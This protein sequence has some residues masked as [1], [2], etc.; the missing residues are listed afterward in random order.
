[1]SFC[2]AIDG[3]SGAGKSTIADLLAKELNIPHLDTGAMYRA[4]AYKAITL[5][6]DLNDE[7]S[8]KDMLESTNVHVEFENNQQI[9][10]LDGK[11]VTQN[12]REHRVSEA[13]SIIST[14][15]PTRQ[16]MTRAQ[17]EIALLY[18]L[19]IDG[20]DIGSFVL[21]NAKYKFYLTASVEERAKRRC[22]ELVRKGENVDYLT[23]Y[24]DIKVRDHR[25]MTREYAPLVQ[26]DDAIL[27]D[28]TF[29]TPEQV[30][31]FMLSHIEEADKK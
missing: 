20:R 12:I 7:N 3:P 29:M 21:P 10:I 24:E 27:I 2:I 4:L 31:S 5:N 25:D 22:K 13:A 16:K 17:Q 28:S 23:I 18:D 1:M 11:D 15:L 19:V 9:T 14:Y 8:I 30:V 6:I 26:A